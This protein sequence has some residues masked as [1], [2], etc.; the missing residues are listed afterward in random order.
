TRYTA[1]SRGL[2]DV[3]KRQARARES[4]EV[5]L[6]LPAYRGRVVES[7]AALGISRELRKPIR[8]SRLRD[9]L[10]QVLAGE[11]PA[12]SEAAHAV[13]AIDPADRAGL[14]RIRVLL[15][16]DHPVNRKVA[17]KL[18]ERVGVSV[19]VAEN[20]QEALEM[21][22]GRDY[23]L[24]FMDVQMPVMDG[25]RAAALIRAREERTGGHLPIV[26]MTA[27][28]TVDDRNRCLAS[29]MDDYLAKPVTQADLAEAIE[30][31]RRAERAPSIGA[32]TGL[33]RAA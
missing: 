13:S 16:E 27:N 15:V 32:G 26:A 6:L 21:T 4:T 30:K 28:A 7:I 24:V 17:V 19:E 5:V 1:L 18:L 8:R 20:G 10:Q 9:T 3:Y 33:G 11:Q 14:G 22:A 31:Q 23:D 12:P 25:I 29:G 2:G